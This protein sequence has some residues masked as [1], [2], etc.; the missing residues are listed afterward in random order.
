M[1]CF[2]IVI[3]IVRELDSIPVMEKMRR[4]CLTSLTVLTGIISLS[5]AVADF[6]YAG[7]YRDFAENTSKQFVKQKIWFTG[8]WGFRYYMEQ[9]DAHYLYIN[10]NRPQQGD[11]VVIPSL[12]CPT[13]LPDLFKRMTLKE[14]VRIGSAFPMRIMN[15][16]AKAAFYSH[17]WGF[18]P[19]SFSPAY[20]EEFRIY[21]VEE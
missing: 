10:D 17:G 2:P 4:A 15:N 11:I 16:T 6:Q 5:A 14:T 1:L 12:P 19:Y 7:I 8:E 3:L 13:S 20:L 21:T 18:L 9:N